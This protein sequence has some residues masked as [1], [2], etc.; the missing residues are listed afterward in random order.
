M[1][2]DNAF[3]WLAFVSGP[4]GDPAPLQAYLQHS[5][6]LPCAIIRGALA[7][8]GIVA[9]VSAEVSRC[10]ACVFTVHIQS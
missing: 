1:L 8:L 2:H 6:I 7:G 9:E 10:P 4:S 3:R 5:T